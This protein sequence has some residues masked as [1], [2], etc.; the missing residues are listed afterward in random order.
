M[1]EQKGKVVV[2]M[3]TQP[4]AAERRSWRT[5]AAPFLGL[6]LLPIATAS[7]ANAAVAAKGDWAKFQFDLGNSGFNRF[8]STTNAGNVGHLKQAWSVQTD[9]ANPAQAGDVV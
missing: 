8:E 7:T 9:T 4:G 2:A 1:I 5:W 6:L 3:G